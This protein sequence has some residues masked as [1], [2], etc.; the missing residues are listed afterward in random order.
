MK[1]YNKEKLHEYAKELFALC[2]L[3][4]NVT[5]FD[6]IDNEMIHIKFKTDKWN[7]YYSC[8]HRSRYNFKNKQMLPIWEL[9]EK[10]KAL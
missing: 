1:E 7:D 4:D 5:Y 2:L 9:I 10:V 3:N 6:I 8:L